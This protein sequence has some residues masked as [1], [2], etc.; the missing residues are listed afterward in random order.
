MCKSF[1]KLGFGGERQIE[2]SGGCFPPQC[3]SGELEL[4]NFNYQVKRMIG[5]I[6]NMFVSVQCS[7]CQSD[8]ISNKRG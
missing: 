4:R 5:G 6:E 7:E 3:P 2:P 8:E 1:V